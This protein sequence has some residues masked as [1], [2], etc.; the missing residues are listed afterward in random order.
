MNH[1]TSRLYTFEQYFLKN[2]S[3]GGRLHAWLEEAWLPAYKRL[4]GGTA[5][6]VMDAIVA[7]QVPQVAV[8]AEWDSYAQWQETRAAMRA[9]ADMRAALAYWEDHAEPPYEH[10]TQS[11][12][13]ATPYSPALA[14]GGEKAR[15][16]ELRVYHAPAY[17]QLRALHDRFEGPEIPIF[18]RCGIHPALYTSALFGPWMPNLIYFTPFDSL[19]AR[20]A[21]WAKFMADEEWVRVRT[22]SVAEHGQINAFFKVALY[23]AAGYSPV[24]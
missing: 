8:V 15:V 21:A 7:E 10:F 5:A 6:L 20:E 14:P 2:S 12:L 24:K 11:L 19:G 18:H 16:F 22:E 17:R 13:E 3:Q 1:P 23:R 9:D 4:T